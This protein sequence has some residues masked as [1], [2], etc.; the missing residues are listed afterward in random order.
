MI[1]KKNCPPTLWMAKLSFL[2]VFVILNNLCT[3]LPTQ[4]NVLISFPITSE[5]WATLGNLFPEK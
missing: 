5:E 3:L 1:G 2:K 4:E